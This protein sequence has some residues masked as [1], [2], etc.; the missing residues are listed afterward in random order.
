MYAY[1]KQTLGSPLLIGKEF[2]RLYQE[3]AWGQGK[4]QFPESMFA[5]DVSPEAYIK[6]K[7]AE[8]LKTITPTAVT[9]LAD[10]PLAPEINA[11]RAIKPHAIVTTNYDQ[12]L[13]LLFP[14]YQ[15]IIGQKVIAGSTVLYGELFKI[16]GCVSEPNSLVFTQHDYEVFAKKKKYLSAKLTTFFSEHPLLFI[17]Y[18]TSDQNIRGILSD[19]D[20]ILSET[21]AVIP[22]VYILEWNEKAPS[23]DLPSREKLV[24]IEGARSVRIKAIETDSFQWVFEA[25][26][27]AQPVSVIPLKLLRALLHRAHDI[28]RYDVPKQIVEVNFK[29]LEHAVELG[30]AFANLLGITTVDDATRLNAD[31]PH[32]SSML[33]EHLFGDY[34][35]STSVNALIK[36]LRL[37]TGID[38]K[39]SDNRYHILTKTGRKSSTHKSS[40]TLL[41]LLQ[42]MKDGKPYDFK[43]LG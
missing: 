20:E 13:E 39:E 2:A 32:T 38:I 35:K 8:H 40:D 6:Y 3:W 10:H 7:I 37:E 33:A 19:I 29:T 21:G 27:A 12:F 4:N 34:N 31:F 1:Y 26:A 5:S 42:K 43:P 22:N 18:S 11:L 16:H 41:I 15:P 24:E 25:L 17:G 30:E 28:K 36:R 23:I 9:G 14:D